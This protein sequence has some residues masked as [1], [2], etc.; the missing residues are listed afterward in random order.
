MEE[1]ILSVENYKEKIEAI[2]KS[3]KIPLPVKYG[4]KRT[5][6][7]NGEKREDDKDGDEWYDD[8]YACYRDMHKNAMQ[9][10][11]KAMDCLDEVPI[12]ILTN[13]IERISVKA[14]SFEDIFEMYEM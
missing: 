5:G 12:T 8:K 7:L 9:I 13:K 6:Y 1:C 3:Y 14:G 11:Q 4:W 10:I 2:L